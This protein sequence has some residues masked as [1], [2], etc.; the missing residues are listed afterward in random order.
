MNVEVVAN[1]LR[2]AESGFVSGLKWNCLVELMFKIVL[3]FVTKENVV[4]HSSMRT[5][6]SFYLIMQ[7]TI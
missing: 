2:L 5:V 7:S 1:N 3:S 4:T 6:F